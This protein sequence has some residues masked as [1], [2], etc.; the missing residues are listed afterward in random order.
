[1]D[2]NLLFNISFCLQFGFSLDRTMNDAMNPYL[3]IHQERCLLQSPSMQ[4]TN[5]GAVFF[6]MDFKNML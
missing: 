5:T 2:G 6:I 4:T 3:D 1:M